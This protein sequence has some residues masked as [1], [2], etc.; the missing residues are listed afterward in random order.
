MVSGGFE[1]DMNRGAGA[2]L[3]PENASDLANQRRIA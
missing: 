2:V 1:L 3:R